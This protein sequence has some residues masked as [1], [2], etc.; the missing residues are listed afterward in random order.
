MV[1]TVLAPTANLTPGMLAGDYAGATGSAAV[2]VGAGANVLV[3][4]KSLMLQP[5]SF[6]GTTGLNVAAG[7]AAMSLEYQTASN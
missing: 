7:I 1:W 6:E 4:S 2:G 5:M 3:G